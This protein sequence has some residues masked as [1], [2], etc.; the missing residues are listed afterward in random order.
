MSTQIKDD[1]E[2]DEFLNDKEYMHLKNELFRSPISRHNQRVLIVQP[3][4]KNQKIDST[5][6][7]MLGIFTSLMLLNVATLNFI[8]KIIFFS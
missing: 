1:N 5:P 7:L 8:D 3:Y 6:E 2:I 4:L